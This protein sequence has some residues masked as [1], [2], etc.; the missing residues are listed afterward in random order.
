MSLSKR[1]AAR[2]STEARRA[3]LWRA[4]DLD[5]VAV[6]IGDEE[7]GEPG[8]SVAADN[9]MHRV[10]LRRV[11]AKTV[12]SQHG[13][14]TVEMIGAES[15]M[16]TVVVDVAGPEGA[17]RMDDQ[18]HLHGAAGKPGAGGLK[19]RPLHECELEQVLIE[20]LATAGDQ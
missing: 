1:V 14:G 3:R 5:D 17:G 2:V 11:F 7:L 6:G 4:V 12:G 16:A 9:D 19:G 18:M 8:R 13:E 10:V 15:Q 20:R